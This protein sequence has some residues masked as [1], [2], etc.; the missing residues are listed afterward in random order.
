MSLWE[1]LSFW[2]KKRIQFFLIIEK[3]DIEIYVGLGLT[4]QN[5]RDKWI[6]VTRLWDI[7]NKMVWAKKE[8]LED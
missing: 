4:V 5:N 6:I 1:L 8:T 3:A 7:L 2:K